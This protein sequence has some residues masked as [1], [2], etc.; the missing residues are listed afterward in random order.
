MDTDAGEDADCICAGG[1]N[2]AFMLDCDKCHR[3]FHGKCVGVAEAEEDLPAEWFCDSC[4]LSN[5]VADQRQRITRLLTLPEGGGGS[6]GEELELGCTEI[7]VTKQLA[8]NYLQTTVADPAAA[9]A[10]GAPPAQ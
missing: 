2:G 7:E 5:A 1:Y 3:W 8:M 6:D 9:S 4:Q 10:G